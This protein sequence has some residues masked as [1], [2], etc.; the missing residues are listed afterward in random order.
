MSK[1]MYLAQARY[2]LRMYSSLVAGA[3]DL[4][5]DQLCRTLLD[6]PATDA[7]AAAATRASTVKFALLF[8]EPHNSAFY[9]KLGW[10]TFN[11]TVYA[12]QPSSG[13]ATFDAMLPYVFKIKRLLREGTIDL[14]GLPW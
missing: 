4:R 12:E 14:C 1:V 5:E 10:Q 2:W 3:C 13:R 11:G 8:C 7:R 6:E 9:E